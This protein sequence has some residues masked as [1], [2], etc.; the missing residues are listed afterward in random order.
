MN[1]LI[2]ST[3][4]I[5]PLIDLSRKLFGISELFQIIIDVILILCIPLFIKK[6]TPNLLSTLFL[7]FSFFL[8]FYTIILF[9]ARGGFSIETV[10]TFKIYLLFC[11]L[12]FFLAFGNFEHTLNKNIILIPILLV[13]ILIFIQTIFA[14]GY[15]YSFLPSLEHTFRSFGDEEISLFSGPFSSSKKCARYLLFL[16]TLYMFKFKPSIILLTITGLAISLTGAREGILLFL[17]SIVF[18]NWSRLP[19]IILIF[20]LGFLMISLVDNLGISYFL[21]AF[22]LDEIMARIGNVIPEGTIQFQEDNLIGLGASVG[23][24]DLDIQKRLDQLRIDITSTS[25]AY[26]SGI[27]RIVNE[28]GILGLFFIIFITI[29]VLF[30]LFR[31]QDLLTM[32]LIIFFL[33]LFIKAHTILLNPAPLII[34][35]AAKL[36]GQSKEAYENRSYV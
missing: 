16:I 32:L 10:F 34:M 19:S 25:F 20:L 7:I 8:L 5:Y 31:K 2:Y 21:S 11:L 1:F 36:N 13:S 29:F 18:L 9:L 3:I 6:F 33:V 22:S 30:E 15:G 17:F 24:S 26:D 14:I 28:I 4:L 23:D 35:L 12:L 27:L